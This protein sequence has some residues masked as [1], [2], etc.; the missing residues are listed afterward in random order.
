VARQTPEFRASSEDEANFIDPD[1][2]AYFVT[3]EHPIL[4]AE[5]ELAA[6]EA[7]HQKDMAASKSGDYETLRSVMSDDAV[8][9]PPGGKRLQGKAE[10]DA[11]GDESGRSAGVC[12]GF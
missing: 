8:L 12:S 3:Q 2:V 4:D 10:L 7:L 9:M 6:I 11:R 5:K 1:K